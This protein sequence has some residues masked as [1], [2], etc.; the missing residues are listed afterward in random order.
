MR[1]QMTGSQPRESNRNRKEQEKEK[2]YEEEA[3]FRCVG[4]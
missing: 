3:F 2:I 4:R 1:G